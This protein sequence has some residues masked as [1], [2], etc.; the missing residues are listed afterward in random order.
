MQII[1]EARFIR[2]KDF[3]NKGEIKLPVRSIEKCHL[4]FNGPGNAG[5]GVKRTA[6]LLPESV[7]L[8]VA[9]LCCGRHGTIAGKKKRL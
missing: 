6:L 4:H 3:L 2:V 1:D 5:F 8:L 9:P 7:M